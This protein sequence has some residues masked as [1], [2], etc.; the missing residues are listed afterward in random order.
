[1][2]ALDHRIDHRVGRDLDAVASGEHVGKPSTV[3]ALDLAEAL[4]E[5]GVVRER[6]KAAQTVEVRDPTFADSLGDEC[7]Q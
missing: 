3:A 6:L 1:M 7:R 4:A 5:S 2:K